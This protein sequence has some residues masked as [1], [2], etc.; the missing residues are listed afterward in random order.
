MSVCGTSSLQTSLVAPFFSFF[1]LAVA[2]SSIA[3]SVCAQVPAPKPP[4]DV[5]V[6]SN[7]NH[8]DGQIERV[9]GN[10]V[11][12]KSDEVGEIKISLDKVKS[13]R[14]SRNFAV[15]RKNMPVSSGAVAE[16]TIQYNDKLLT[17]TTRQGTTETLPQNEIAY[18]IGQAAYHRAL[19]KNPGLLYGWKGSVNGGATVV[20]STDNGSTYTAGIAL[21]RSISALPF[22]PARNR[23]IFNLQ[24]T[25][26]KLTSPVIPQTT[27]PTPPAVTLTS[28]FHS[29]V[30]RDQYFSP[31]FFALA[32]VSFDHNYSQGLQLQQVYGSGIGWTAIKSGKQEMDVKASLQY[33]KQAFQSPSDNRN[34]VG[35]TI[36]EAYRRTLP[37]KMIFTESASVLPAWN[38]TNAYSANVSAGLAMPVFKRL[39]LNVGSTDNFLNNPSAGYKKNSFQFITAIAYTLK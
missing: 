8:M 10:S 24:E 2:S 19:E 15:L 4:P 22:L 36:A 16:G 35:S 31:R 12:F 37:R 14:S 27:P 13:L 18:I 7:G 23:T 20:R 34:L 26:G 21:V 1:L 5:V 25:Y 32:Q 39:S 28:I 3:L 17:V 38:D 11:V 29:E 33:E 9:I 6:F 30:E